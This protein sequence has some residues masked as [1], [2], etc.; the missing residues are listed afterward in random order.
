[1]AKITY[2]ILRE[3][4]M[5]DDSVSWGFI[6][7]RGS[8]ET[9]GSRTRRLSSARYGEGRGGTRDGELCVIVEVR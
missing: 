7:P 9:N 8:C 5:V 4:G 3:Q 2:E 1:M 6:R